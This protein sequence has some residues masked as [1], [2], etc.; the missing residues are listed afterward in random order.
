MATTADSGTLQL[1][2]NATLITDYETAIARAK[3]IGGLADGQP[4]LV[5]Y[6]DNGKP[7]VILVIGGKAGMGNA[8]IDYSEVEKLKAETYT[9]NDIDGTFAT[10]NE[11]DSYQPKG[12]YATKT[13]I[14]D[15]ATET[16]V[17]SRGF[18]TEHQSLDE[19]AKLTDIPDVTRFFNGV[20][21]VKDRKE[22]Q[23]KNN[24]S[25]LA[26]IDTTDFIKDGML[27]SVTLTDGSNSNIGKRVLKLIFNT[28][29]GKDPIELP[30]SDIFNV[31]NYYSKEQAEN[32]FAKKS[33]TY[34]KEDADS[35]FVANNALQTLTVTIE[36][37]TLGYN[38]KEAK[39]I[40]IDR[41][42]SGKINDS[43]TVGG[44]INSAIEASSRTLTITQ[45]GI[46]VGTYN[47]KS[48]TSINITV[49]TQITDLGGITDLL[50]DYAKTADVTKT[51]TIQ[52]NGVTVGTYDGTE[53]KTINITG[54]DGG[55]ETVTITVGGDLAELLQITDGVLDYKS[56]TPTITCGTF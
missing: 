50:R 6:T 27:E 10:K 23:F 45:N 49:P 35:K 19:Y 9:K 36:G 40:N 33:D 22:I 56:E 7:M 44:A 32:T 42:V 47:G 26:T 25:V 15:M 48:D 34:T 38:T 5:Q 17:N 11:L 18:L 8:I 46:G 20:D 39:S 2:R 4:C 30:I 31:D 54:T 12:D 43:L 13:E 3:S 1:Y 14:A 37:E 21:Y 24:D 29:A 51:L 16:W 41:A 28:D 53:S 55:G 52:K